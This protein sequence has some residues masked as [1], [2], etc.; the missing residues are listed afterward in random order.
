MRA[1]LR[2]ALLPVA[3]ALPV[4][5]ADVTAD[6][7]VINKARRELLLMR[8][9]ALLRSYRVALGFDPVGPKTR[10]GDGKTPEGD[11]IISGRNRYSRF[12]RSL[13]VSYP[14]ARD[15]ARAR[16]LRVNP[17]GDIMIHGLPREAAHIG[18]AHTLTDWT[19]GCIA[20]TN[21]EIEE[22][23]RLVPDG[24]PVRINP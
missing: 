5:A 4:A 10:Q 21:S 22:I 1:L 16:R 9:G 11:Y 12:H 3:F 24:I 15:R 14:N 19:L 18:K 20:V 13:Q 23:W 17:G 7:I 6:A 8:G 2:L